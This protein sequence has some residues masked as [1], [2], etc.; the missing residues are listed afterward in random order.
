MKCVC[1][2][3]GVF[4]DRVFQC[5]TLFNCFQKHIDLGFTHQPVWLTENEAWW[6]APW[7]DLLFILVFNVIFVAVITGVVIDTFGDMRGEQEQT[8]AQLKNHCLICN[9]TRQAFD[10]LEDAG[11]VMH[12]Q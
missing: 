1:S 3:C 7:Y 9:K 10:C 4:V 8:R 6:G 2:V 11:D 5:D 12:T